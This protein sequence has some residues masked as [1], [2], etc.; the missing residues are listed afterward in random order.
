LETT[1]PLAKRTLSADSES[2]AERV[3]AIALLSIRGWST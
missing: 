3:A 1:T 2:K